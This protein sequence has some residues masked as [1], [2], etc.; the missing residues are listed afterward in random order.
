MDK[1][2]RSALRRF[3]RVQEFLATHA[4]EGTTVKLQ[5]LDDVVRDMT[6][7]GEEEDASTRLTLGETKSQRALREDLWNRHMVPI[8]RIA[9]RAFGVPGMDV[10]FALPKK[11]SDNEAILDAARGMAQAAAQH[12]VVFVE[13]EG[14]PADFLQQM[15]AAIDAL[16]S[17]LTTRVEGQRRRK[18]SREALEKL[19]KRG[20]A[21]VDVLD[22]IVKPRLAD[23]PELL[24]AWNSV[25]RP[26]EPGGSVSTEPAA[27][28]TSSP[29]A[30][31]AAAAAP[32]T[33][34]A[35]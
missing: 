3:R 13:Q 21:A 32:A 25:K 17:A 33:V 31:A 14:L 5:A 20:V 35:A 11:L 9:R 19:V 8:S 26:T 34:K 16:A 1:K 2:Q 22:A 4:V 23:T 18:T 27:S 7:G 28:A 30:A 29:P 15:H 10:K 6:A 12:A 24:A